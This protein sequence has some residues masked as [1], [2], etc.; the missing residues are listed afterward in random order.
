MVILIILGVVEMKVQLDH[1]SVR[2]IIANDPEFEVEVRQA[3]LRSAMKKGTEK[4]LCED[5]KVLVKS[6][7]TEALG[8]HGRPESWYWAPPDSFKEKVRKEID[9]KMSEAINQAIDEKFSFIEGKVEE[10]LVKYIS[11]SEKVK[12]QGS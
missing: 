8:E 2:D 7:I 6:M 5:D 10:L 1:K 12:V 4:L 3:I 9:T 11:N